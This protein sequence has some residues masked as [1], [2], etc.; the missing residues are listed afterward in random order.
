MLDMLGLLFLPRMYWMAWVPTYIT[1]ALIM[2]MLYRMPG[3]FDTWIVQ[4][5]IQ[6]KFCGVYPITDA[7]FPFKNIFF[8]RQENFSLFLSTA[9][10][11]IYNNIYPC[12]GKRGCWPMLV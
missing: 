1:S 8:T 11:S 3:S 5:Y 12:N 7:I 4:G 9:K 6:I 10:I 2:E